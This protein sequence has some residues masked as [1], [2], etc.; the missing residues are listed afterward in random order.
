MCTLGSGELV[1][2]HLHTLRA[3]A[4]FLSAA[5]PSTAH[6]QGLPQVRGSEVAEEEI[7]VLRREGRL[8]RCP[9][10]PVTPLRDPLQEQGSVLLCMGPGDRSQLRPEGKRLPAI[11]DAEAETGY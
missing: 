5:C 9:G 4:G 2:P 6:Y 8:G 11:S 10:G 1:R 3:R 7:L